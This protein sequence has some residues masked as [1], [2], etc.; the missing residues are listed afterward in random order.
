MTEHGRSAGNV[1]YIRKVTAW[2]VVVV[3]GPK[4]TFWTDGSTRPVH[5]GW[6]FVISCCLNLFMIFL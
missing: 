4:L 3:C 6:L 2:R 1:V 5:Y